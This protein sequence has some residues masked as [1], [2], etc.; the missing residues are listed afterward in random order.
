MAVIGAANAALQAM[1]GAQQGALMAAGLANNINPIYSSALNAV[2]PYSEY[3]SCRLGRRKQSVRGT[4]RR[5]SAGR[6]VDPDAI[7]RAAHAAM[8]QQYL[9]AMLAQ[10]QAHH[11]QMMQAI[12]QKML[13]RDA[14]TETQKQSRL[15]KLAQFFKKP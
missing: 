6:L 13:D 4:S 2:K 8:Q 11:E 12:S 10:Q 15:E 3:S 14:E 1:A 9:Q 7:S 5:A